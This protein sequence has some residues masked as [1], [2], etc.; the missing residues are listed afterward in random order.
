M[1]AEKDEEQRRRWWK[2]NTVNEDAT[3]HS[4]LGTSGPRLG[5]G[6]RVISLLF[7]VMVEVI[8]N[9]TTNN[10]NHDNV[11]GGIVM[12]KIIARVHPVHLINV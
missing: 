5:L 1:D 12:T 7:K 6:F 10:N 8:I 2:E 9:T 4:P 3:G 11:Y